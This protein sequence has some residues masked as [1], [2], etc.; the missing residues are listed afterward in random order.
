MLTA[1]N[2]DL[3]LHNGKIV[4]VDSRFTIQQAVAM[5]SG[6]ITVVGPDS[7]VLKAERGRGHAEIGVQGRNREF[8]T[9]AY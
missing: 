6:V 4:T 2:A 9:L 7:A 1:A 8:F 3:I 5:R